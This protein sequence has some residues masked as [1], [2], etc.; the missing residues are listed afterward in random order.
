MRVD[1]FDDRACST[2]RPDP[3]RLVEEPTGHGESPGAQGKQPMFEQ[4]MRNSIG[5]SGARSIIGQGEK[6]GPFRTAG[7][8]TRLSDG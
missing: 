3:G 4:H 2:C 6:V 5:G 7:R 1:P 8:S